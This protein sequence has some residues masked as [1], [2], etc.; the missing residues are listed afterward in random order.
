LSQTQLM[1]YLA[2]GFYCNDSSISTDS[3]IPST[4]SDV[5]Q[6]GQ[7]TILGEPTETSILSLGVNVC[8]RGPIEK[9]RRNLPI[10]K[11]PFEAT[12]KFM[13]TMHELNLIELSEGVGLLEVSDDMIQGLDSLFFKSLMH[14]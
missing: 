4:R 12:S 8:G 9:I 5:N 14:P 2:P 10:E 7:Y 11:I 6:E 3:S 13:A 1:H